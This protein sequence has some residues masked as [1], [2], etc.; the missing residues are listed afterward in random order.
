MK[1]KLLFISLILT[2]FTFHSNAQIPT[3]SICPEI[4]GV[5]IYGN[6][7]SLSEM[8]AEGQ[9]VILVFGAFWAGPVLTYLETG[10]VNNYYA[11][12]GLGNNGL[13]NA[14]YI[15]ADPNS[16]VQDI[17]ASGIPDLVDFPIMN[18]PGNLLLDFEITYFPTVYSVCANGYLQ[19]IDQLTLDQLQNPTFNICSQ[20]NYALNPMLISTHVTTDCEN[21]NVF[22]QMQNLGSEMM[23]SCTIGLT[24]DQG[25]I[26]TVDWTGN[27]GS[28][29]W[30]WVDLGAYDNSVA[31]IFHISITSADEAVDAPIDATIFQVAEATSH[32]RIDLLT[33]DFPTE[34]SW[35]I[36]NSS[37]E[38]IASSAMYTEPNH[39]YL[40]DINVSALDCYSLTIYDSYGD[41]LAWPGSMAGHLHVN[42][43]EED[44]D[45]IPIYIYNGDYQFSEQNAAFGVTT[46]VPLSISGQV[47]LDANENAYNEDNE[48]GIGGIE[49]QL[50]DMITYTDENGN[51]I[52]SDVDP[53]GTLSI[54]YDSELYPTATT[55]TSYDLNGA[56]QMTYNFGLSTSDPSYNLNYVYTEPWFFCGFDGMIWFHVFNAGNTTV[57][58]QVTLELDPLLTCTGAYP[59]NFT[60]TGNIYTWNL[61]N[62]T[63]GE[64]LYFSFNIVNPGFEFMGQN[65][66]NTVTLLTYDENMAIVDQDQDSH[67]SVLYCSYDP[68]DKAGVPTGE[69]EAHYI[70]NGTDL[71]YLIRFQNTGN[72]QAFNIHVLDALDSDLDWSTFSV[73]STS[74]YCQP[75][76]DMATGEIDFFFPD[77]NLADSATNEAASHGFIRYRISPLPDLEELTPIENTAYIYFDFNP[78]I[79]TNTTLHTISDLY[80]SV[81]EIDE[82]SLSL[83]PNPTN[84]QVQIV[85]PIGIGQ[86]DVTISDLQGRVVRRMEKLNGNRLQVSCADLPQGTYW[87]RLTSETE[88]PVRPAQLVVGK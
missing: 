57:N 76:V 45:E 77:I 43:I 27:L 15:E 72:Y 66:T 70:E 83:Y 54:T 18:D 6:P 74:H 32:I 82:Q 31:D 30:V 13:V 44:G 29:Q 20:S 16:T 17:I 19:L 75:T 67:A 39:Q 61:E 88:I 22:V 1:Q 78:A 40:H 8:L 69:T 62:V 65:I 59:P 52:F 21:S 33:D 56:A 58:G 7:V 2:F 11:E 50:N 64:G 12:N 25:I 84:D 36:Q 10:A 55:S 23:T 4:E 41:G 37:N 53:G 81:D 80:F 73:I 49:V 14:I 24:S 48:S 9:N 5:D 79:I 46:L 63:P 28:G 86:Y 68:N 3:G 34:I 38:V 60:N 35:Q 42:A 87:V 85:V 71:E 26:N 47:Y 51:F